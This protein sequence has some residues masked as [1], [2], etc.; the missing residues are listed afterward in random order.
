ML[1]LIVIYE[2]GIVLVGL[3]VAIYLMLLIGAIRS[4]AV[5]VDLFHINL[6][7]SQIEVIME[8]FIDESIILI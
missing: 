1:Q 4:S 6:A 2:L 8:G 3:I 5:I 7:A